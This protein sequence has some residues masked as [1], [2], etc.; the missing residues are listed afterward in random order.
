MKNIKN[1][2]VFL[3]SSLFLVS[4]GR[5]AAK[6]VVEK[7]EDAENG[8]VFA[9]NITKDYR[10]PD[11]RG[12][13]DDDEDDEQVGDVN[14]V[15]LHYVND[16]NNCATRAFYIWASGVDG[17][18]YSSKADGD[19]VKY[20][21]DGG[22][23]TITIDFE[24]ARFAE[25]KEAKPSALMYII[26]YQMIS[27]SNLNWGGQSEDVELKF[28]SFPP[29]NGTVE[30]WCTPAA[31]GGIAQFATEAETKV[32]GVKLAYFTDFKTIAC[33]LTPTA[34]TVAWD[35]YAFDETYYKVKSKNR[36][37]I[38]KNYLVKSG[39][40]AQQNF[41][42]SFKYNAH[43][44]VVYAIESKDV[45]STTGLVKTVFVS[46]EKLY[47]KDRFE[48]KYTYKGSDLGMSYTP[49]ATTFKVWS[50]VA[51]NITLQV[52]DSDTSAAY[53]GDDKY[54]GYH[55]FYQP[56]GVWALELKGDLKG[57]YY[58]YQVDT[59]AGNSTTIDP[60]ATGAGACGIRGFI[61]DKNGA[62]VKPD[63]WDTLPEKW[64]GV[65]NWNNNG[66][67]LDI[68]T[69]QR[70]AVYE[71]H[72]Q[73][74]TGDKS[75]VSN[76]GNANGTFN[77]F[78]ETGTVLRDENNNPVLKDGKTVSTGFD[79]LKELGVNAVQLMPVF[80]S[81]NDEVK[82]RKY[83]WGY[84]PQN[85]NC[86]E[87][88]YSSNPHDGYARIKEFRNL[89]LRCA[90]NGIRVIM[91]VVYNHVS[92]ASAHS[93]NKLMPRYFF[94][95]DENGEL[96]DGSGC[97]NEFRSEATMARK[98][99]VDSLCMWAKDYKIK[100]FR[101]D[102]MGLLDVES[103][104]K[105][106][107]ELFKIDPDIYLYGEG[108]T[109]GGFHGGYDYENQ[110]QSEG[111]FCCNGLGNQVYSQLFT[112]D[113]N[114]RDACY[115]GG[116]ND[117]GRNA[118]KGGNDMGW[119][120]ENHLPGYGWISQGSG[121]ASER[122]RVAIE[123]LIWGA[124]ANSEN[125]IGVNP[126]QTINYAS[127]HDNWTLRDQLYQCLGADGIA[128]NGYDI[129]HGSE[130][131]HALVFTS[132]A[133]A[134]MLGGEE[135]LRTKDVDLADPALLADN[136]I[137]ADSYETM[138]GHHTSHNSYNSPLIVNSFKW[139]NKVSVEFDKGIENGVRKDPYTVD[140]YAEKLTEKFAKMIELHKSMPKYDYEAIY[141]EGSGIRATK[142]TT[143]GNAIDNFSWT[144]SAGGEC[145]FGIQFDEYFIYAS[146]RS[147]G[148]VGTGKSILSWTQKLAVGG[149]VEYDNESLKLGDF[150]YQN[151]YACGVYYAGGKR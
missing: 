70:L 133:T 81:D 49:T 108:W 140:T 27:A 144:G 104:K 147:F 13:G 88:V 103:L 45:D 30:V 131:V 36:A 90:Q 132:N 18:E 98:Y 3:L 116:F 87:G 126:K 118:L 111:A 94:R 82:N 1:T 83:N 33:T 121:D 124:H 86:V 25:I 115:L 120:S 127:C 119:G 91:D 68:D 85:Y 32:D 42:I 19:I 59:W 93:F 17:T 151:G 99:M 113:D 129:M 80:D 58:A 48:E 75:W 101:F 9:T 53:N 89:I 107:K 135:I 5:E 26:K 37:A 149:N 28:S 95:Y 137:P 97:H 146:G 14:K 123:Q 112:T 29:V 72:I 23:M 150:G 145:A 21:D 141:K 55:M 73:D 7:V 76:H 10:Q 110:K 117:L 114:T 2:L 35:L 41:T 24:D 60:Y 40:T 77:A 46:F 57:K 78:V 148:R 56:N 20:S 39:Q 134:F 50:P 71:V 139:G 69:P 105:A 128:G 8:Y 62:E 67:N 22:M 74:F 84:N 11:V 44:N 63:I 125:T 109:S 61:Y 79:H 47:Y 136:S 142:M 6:A 38:K 92:S 12:G 130:A 122:N 138:Y 15:I 43:M 100:G 16:D 143:K 51:A 54:K 4:C 66:I 52:Y 106:Q 96:Y 34:G 102:L 31:G 64:D 65:T